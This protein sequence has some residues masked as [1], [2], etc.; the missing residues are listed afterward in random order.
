M[1]VP[2][3]LLYVYF[4]SANLPATL[5]QLSTA[6]QAIPGETILMLKAGMNIHSDPEPGPND[7]QDRMDEDEGEDA[8][9]TTTTSRVYRIKGANAAHQAK[10]RKH[11]TCESMILKHAASL[12][13][14][15]F[16]TKI[17]TK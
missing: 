16:P 2:N 3:Y 13:S 1:F 14:S 4:P 10:K 6:Q 17:F 9:Q 5:Q 8:D 7:P 11:V 15:S 12:N